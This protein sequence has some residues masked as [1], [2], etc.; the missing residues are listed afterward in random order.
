MNESLAS[1]DPAAELLPPLVRDIADV[2][3]LQATLVL[4]D[5]W[6]GIRWSVPTTH[7]ADSTLSRLIGAD[8]AEAFIRVFGGEKLDLPRC[9]RA[10]IAAEHAALYADRDRGMT[11]PALALKYRCTERWVWELLARRREQFNQNQMGLL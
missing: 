11:A 8:C 6:G 7:R 5:A 10:L 9:T 1:L 2:I 4:C 3:G